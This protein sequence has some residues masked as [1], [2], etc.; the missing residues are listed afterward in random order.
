MPIRNGICQFW[1]HCPVQPLKKIHNEQLGQHRE[2]FFFWISFPESA[3][4]DYPF[5]WILFPGYYFIRVVRTFLEIWMYRS[6]S[7]LVRPLR[8]M[9]DVP[10][11]SK[12]DHFFLILELTTFY[13][14]NLNLTACTTRAVNVRSIQMEYNASLGK[15]LRI[16]QLK[17]LGISSF[18]QR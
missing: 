18:F 5:T 9:K 3:L 13:L 14:I 17:N 2:W 11:D 4:S 8:M 1:D 6:N 15:N 16:F 7:T 10:Y 12:F